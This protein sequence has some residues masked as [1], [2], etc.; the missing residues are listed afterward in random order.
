M[1]A[2]GGW[3]GNDAVVTDELGFA[4]QAGSVAREAIGSSQ[5][6]WEWVMV[7]R[8]RNVRMMRSGW[9]GIKQRW[10]GH[11]FLI[12]SYVCRTWVEAHQLGFTML[13]GRV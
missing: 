10:F 5:L 13:L 1:Y 4:A 9:R 2:F 3:R 8:R 7:G 6:S 12:V 11:Y